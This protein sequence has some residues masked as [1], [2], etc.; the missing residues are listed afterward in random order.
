MN[1]G[2]GEIELLF[3]F[4]NHKRDRTYLLFRKPIKIISAEQ[5]T[6]VVQALSDVHDA[7]KKGLYAAGYVSYEAAAA[8]DPIYQTCLKGNMPIVWFALFEKPEIIEQSSRRSLNQFCI[9]GWKPNITR[10]EYSRGIEKIKSEIKKGNTYQ[11]NYTIRLHSDFRGDDFAFFDHLSQAQQGDYSAYLNTGRY[12]ILSASPELFFRLENNNLTVKPMKGT[13]RRGLDS[14]GDQKQK[15]FLLSS[16]K[17]QAENLMIVDLLRNDLGRIAIN[18]SVQVIKLFEIEKYPTVYQMTSTIKA[19]I[20]STTTLTEIF[21][22]LFPCGSITGAPKAATMKVIAALEKTAREVYCGAIGYLS[23]NGNAVFNVPIRTVLIDKE[24]DTAQ[25]GVGGGITWDSTSVDEYE[26]ILTKA[27]LL[28]TKKEKFDLLETILLEKGTYTRLEGHLKR[29]RASAEYFGYVYSETDILRMLSK[30]AALYPEKSRRVRLLLA[31]NGRVHI[32]SADFLST[33]KE[34]IR[35]AIIADKPIDRNNC[36]IYHKTTCRAVYEEHTDRLKE[37]NKEAVDVLLWNEEKEI[38]EFTIGNIVIEID[39]QK[40]TP[41]ISCGLLAGVFREQ[42]LAQGEIVERIVKME[43]LA[44]ASYI[45]M[46]NSL[47]GW[48]PINVII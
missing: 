26:E 4:E 15:Q 22:A 20:P 11:V 24:S 43:D 32:E 9:G 14:E 47:R 25:Y 42:L 29:L 21:G 6:E 30:H 13:A 44:Y 7:V 38:T 16:E 3:Q 2:N 5:N 33:D 31:E 10:D 23:P 46:I 36:L 19:E 39:G 48:V 40:I 37:V 12:R 35:S 18:G 8:F 41:P 17:N 28:T 1:K 27:A 45:W 34:S